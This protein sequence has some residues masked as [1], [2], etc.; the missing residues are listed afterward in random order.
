MSSSARGCCQCGQVQLNLSGA[1]LFIYVCHCL[2]CQKRTGSAFSMG[3][4]MAADHVAVAGDLTPWTRTSDDGHSNTRHSCS[5][6][7]NII[8]GDSSA[9]PGLWKLQ[10]GLLEDTSQL[11][12]NIHLWTRRKQ[13]WVTLP[14]D[15]T[16]FDTQPDDLSELLTAGQ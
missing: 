7:G 16:C 2:D 4:V 3:L 11:R 15:A 9:T 1:P 6:C 14:E 10:A 8:Y 13:A 12:P 5:Q